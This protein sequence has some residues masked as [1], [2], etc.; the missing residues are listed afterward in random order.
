MYICSLGLF[1]FENETWT[2]WNE[3]N[4]DLPYNYIT[5]L[6]SD[7]NGKIYMGTYSALTDGGAASFD[8]TNWEVLSSVNSGLSDND[9]NAMEMDGSGKLWFATDHGVSALQT[10]LTSTTPIVF[11]NTALKVFPN[12][13]E[14]N[15]TLQFTTNN[16]TDKIR[17][18]IISLD[19]KTISDI[20][21]EGQRSAGLQQLDIQKQGWASGLYYLQV[22]YNE[23]KMVEAILVR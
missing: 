4:S 22:Q 15:A 18:S 21:I 3:N 2:N 6:T 10:T 5:S 1:K 23:V 13:I 20:L 11:E 14:D 16:A 9:V 8:G 12:P 17:I 7:A 19:G